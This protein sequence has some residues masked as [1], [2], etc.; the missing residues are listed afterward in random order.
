MQQTNIEFHSLAHG[1][2]TNTLVVA[3]D[4]GAFLGGKIHGRETV[5][6]VG[7]L[8]VMPG[9]RALH[10]EV[11]RHHTATPGLCHRIGNFI[12]A[13]AIGFGD[14]AGF[15]AFQHLDLYRGIVYGLLQVK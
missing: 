1:L 11:G 7:K 13:V 6:M 12:V 10:H 3:V 4:G 9:I 8:A 2:Q 5:D 14:G 15:K